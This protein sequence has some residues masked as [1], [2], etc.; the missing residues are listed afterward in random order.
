METSG[1]NSTSGIINRHKWN[2]KSCNIL[3]S[4]YNTY[5]NPCFNNILG[6]I[7]GLISNVKSSADTIGK[8]SEM[9]NM[10]SNETAR[11]MN[12]VSLTIEQMAQG[13]D[14]QAQ[15]ISEGVE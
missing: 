10:T 7:G 3:Y 14:S 12:E 13:S 1:V 4:R 8:T 9:I 2:T 6:Q 5:R 11:S 15:D